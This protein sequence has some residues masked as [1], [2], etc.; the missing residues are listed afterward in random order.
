MNTLA[1]AS[2]CWGVAAGMAAGSP[3]ETMQDQQGKT[4]GR[5]VRLAD[6]ESQSAH[7]E[8]RGNV[9]NS[10]WVVCILFSMFFEVTSEEFKLFLNSYRN[11]KLLSSTLHYTKEE[12]ISGS[13]IVYTH[14]KQTAIRKD[15]CWPRGWSLRLPWNPVSCSYIPTPAQVYLLWGLCSARVGLIKMKEKKCLPPWETQTFSFLLK[16]AFIIKDFWTAL[17]IRRRTE[18]QEMFG[19]SNTTALHDF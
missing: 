15:M 14:T 12:T 13:L 11:L 18:S 5:V 19:T 4:P 16:F 2:V 6:S 17:L 9:S 1:L 3:G 10:C 7:E 8:R